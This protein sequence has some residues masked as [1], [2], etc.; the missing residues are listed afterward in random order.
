[1]TSNDVARA[2][3][4]NSALLEDRA[5]GPRAGVSRCAALSLWYVKYRDRDH[6]DGVHARRR[7]A[8]LKRYRRLSEHTRVRAWIRHQ[9]TAK[10]RLDGDLSRVHAITGHGD[11]AVIP[12]SHQAL[13]SALRVDGLSR[14]IGIDAGCREL[15]DREQLLRRQARHT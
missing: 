10:V 13:V 5:V 7:G 2:R 11:A 12:S 1:M 15:G 4:V 14:H 8:S 6:P 3:K 9:S